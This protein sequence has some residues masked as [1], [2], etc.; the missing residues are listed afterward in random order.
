MPGRP[1]RRRQL[2]MF[3]ATVVLGVGGS[4]VSVPAAWATWTDPVPVTGTTLATVLP[5]AP[6]VVCGTLQIGSVTVNWTPVP[7]ATGY[8]LFFGTGGATTVDVAAGVTSRTFTGTTGT[9]SV[10]AIFGTT[11]WLSPTSNSK[12]YSSLAGLLGTCI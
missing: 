11:S 4:F 3:G 1:A 9:F 10:R 6:V 12:Q 7:S 2:T 8:R 5:T